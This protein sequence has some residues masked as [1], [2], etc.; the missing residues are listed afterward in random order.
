MNMHL[1]PCI[2][3]AV[4]AMAAIGPAAV[5]Q[6]NAAA[7]ERPK[8][9]TLRQNEDWSALAG[10]DTSQAGD[11]FDPIKHMG[12]AGYSH[13]FAADFVEQTG[14]GSDIDFFYLQF[15]FMF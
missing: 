5:A 12:E 13:F 3:A 1:P 8:Y 9:Q 10:H 15:L 4:F 14:S 11:F 2:L 6:E 7:F